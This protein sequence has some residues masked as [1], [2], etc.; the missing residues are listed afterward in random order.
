[1]STRIPPGQLSPHGGSA[2]QVAKTS[3]A[4]T[5]PVDDAHR[6]RGPPATMRVI[7]YDE[8]KPLKGIK[9]SRFWIR[10]MIAAKKF[11]API[12]L[13]GKRVAFLEHEIDR[14]IFDRAAEREDAA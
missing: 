12:S 6:P 7:S 9:F 4:K 1:M 5:A 2:S 11:P 14:W 13:G 8:L 3:V 10:Q